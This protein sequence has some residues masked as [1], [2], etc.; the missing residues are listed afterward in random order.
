MVASIHAVTSADYYLDEVDRSLYYVTD[1]AAGVW[2]GEGATALGFHGQVIADELVAAFQ[3]FAPDG[4]R[5]L[6]QQQEHVGKKRQPAW[7]MTFSAPKSV[8]VLWSQLDAHDRHRIEDL[9]MRAAKRALDYLDAECLVTRRGEKGEL[10]ENARGVYALCPHGTSRAQDPQLHI[11][12]LI[13]NLCLRWDGSTGTIW[14]RDLYLHK[15]AA[16]A[17]FRQELAYLLQTELGLS[18]LPEDWSFRLDGVSEALC[19]EQSKRR[20]VIDTLAKET[21]WDSPKILAELA[22]ST[23]DPKGKVSLAECFRHWRQEGEEFGFVREHAE[24]LLSQGEQRLAELSEGR[25]A[26]QRPGELE[27]PIAKSIEALSAFKAYFPERDLVSDAANRAVAQGASATDLLGAVKGTLA[28][29]EHQV[30]VEGSPYAHYSTRE[31]VAAEQ[32]ILDRAERG[33]EARGHLVDERTVAAAQAAVE[34]KLS[35]LLGATVT[36]T[37]DQ[38]AA[39]RHVTLEPGNLKLV[40]GYAGTGKTQMLEAA[41][42]GWTKRGKQVLGVAPTGKAALGLEAATGIRSVTIESLLRRLRPQLTTKEKAKLFINRA[43]DAIKANYWEAKRAGAWR[44][45]PFKQALREAK[46]AA[47]RQLTPGSAKPRPDFRLTKNTILVVDEMGMLPTKPL[48]ALQ[49]E[50]D[51]VGAK[52]VGVGDRL[53]LPPIEAG[54]PFWSL[55]QR[56]GHASLTTVIRQRQAWMREAVGFIIENQPQRALELY[57]KNGAL[58]FEKHTSAAIEKLVA[59]YSKLKA[60]Q[61]RDAIA[62]TSTRDEARRINHAVQAGRKAKRELGLSSLR[63]PNGERV[64]KQDRV[65]LTLNDYRLGVR[66]GLLG[67]VVGIHRTRGIV[68]PGSLTI[69]LD[70]RPKRGFFRV[71]PQ[72]VT[73]DLKKFGDVQLGY[74][75]TT[76]K[77]QGVTVQKS[78]VLMGEAM[79]S[80]EMAFTQL[81]RASHETTLYAARSYDDS[82]LER[83][84]KSVSKVAAKDLAHD[85]T[86]RTMQEKSY[87]RSLML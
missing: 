67:T 63:L 3:G 23:R 1:H 87:G 10:L 36:F 73:I 59:D 76:H 46:R 18:V 27:R 9:V 31:N 70:G 49:Q 26:H 85:H 66:N 65:M 58:H 40:Q 84:A 38:A 48:L 86:L 50:C 75:A 42:H 44:R 47:A 72:L 60:K 35:K 56:I 62:L 15:M 37:D 13:L 52:I 57:A 54:G 71:K 21:G 30:F 6:V 41:N 39:L 24:R 7:D 51:K 64:H 80:R 12:A 43:S 4:S 45:N 33:K 16:G 68:G 77:V 14:S 74:A 32:E 22:I 5:S 83:L 28:R 34:R 61:F 79:L 55:A 19:K 8:S 2:H 69:Q 29:F 17:V 20:Q 78:F 82:Q 81:S 25:S 11:H 53:Q